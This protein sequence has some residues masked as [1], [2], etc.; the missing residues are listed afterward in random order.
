MTPAQKALVRIAALCRRPNHRIT[1]QLRLLELALE[2][3]GVP[4]AVR[5]EE[6]RKVIQVRRD[7]A[8]QRAEANAGGGR[9][10]A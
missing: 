3:L 9:E 7:L 6:I 4:T 1:R 2:G 8:Q 5:D 10:A